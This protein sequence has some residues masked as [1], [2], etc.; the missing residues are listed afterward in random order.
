MRD[1]PQVCAAE[2]REQEDLPLSPV[3]D[4]Q[5]K[6]QTAQ[7]LSL[8]AMSGW[9]AGLLEVGIV[10]Y[11][12]NIQHPSTGM[13]PGMSLVAIGLLLSPFIICGM[14]ILFA[15]GALGGLIARSIVFMLYGG[16][17][18]M[19]VLIAALIVG[20]ALVGL[21]ATWLEVWLMFPDAFRVIFPGLW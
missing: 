18:P 1:K 14:P 16:T 13:T 8:S 11:I 12:S 9:V 19:R 6:P 5:E 20:G 7:Y 15:A 10:V 4:K 2:F 21:V 3:K 17:P